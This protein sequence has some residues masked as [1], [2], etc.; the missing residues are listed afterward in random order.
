MEVVQQQLLFDLSLSTFH[1]VPRYI[2]ILSFTDLVIGFGEVWKIHL[3]VS[4]KAAHFLT[5]MLSVEKMLLFS[6]I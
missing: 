4:A 3:L 5:G 1:I 2:Y 6:L